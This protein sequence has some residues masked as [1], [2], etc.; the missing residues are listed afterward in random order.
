MLLGGLLACTLASRPLQAEVRELAPSRDATL[1]QDNEGDV[2][3]GSAD[4]LFVGRT[5]QGSLRRA[6]V[7]F[8]LSA[9]PAGAVIRSVRLELRVTRTNSGSQSVTL[10]RMLTNWGEGSSNP[11]GEEGAGAPATTGDATW[12]H[13]FYPDQRWDSPGGDFAPT[14]SDT[15]VAGSTGSSLTFSGAGLVADIEHWLANPDQNFG[16]IL[17]GNES[18]NGTAKRLGSRESSNPPEL[19]IEFDPPAQVELPFEQYFPQFGQGQGFFSQLLVTNPHATA[20]EVRVTLRRDDGSPLDTQLDGLATANGVAT[21]DVLPG[22]T[23][24]LATPDSGDL[25]LGSLTLSSSQPVSAAVIFGGSFGLA[26]VLGSDE[27]SDGFFGPV[28]VDLTADI[29]TGLAVQSL[30]DE[31]VTLTLDLLDTTGQVVASVPIDLPAR[32]R[33]VAFVDEIF[34]DYFDQNPGRFIGS[35]RTTTQEDLAAVLIQNRIV[36]GTSQFATLPVTEVPSTP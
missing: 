16:W 27:F 4:G 24:S 1:Y 23:R 34:E 35:V 7:H 2:A 5:N 33:H 6:L 10:H 22:A 28:E 36:G 14:A 30:E 13:T 19:H 8:D 20:V 31:P 15:Q 3:G 32:G 25:L 12:L 18:S 26:G 11:S 9:I 29:R 17:I 21:F